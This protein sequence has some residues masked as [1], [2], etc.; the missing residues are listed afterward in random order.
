MTICHEGRTFGAVPHH[1]EINVAKDGRHLFATHERSL[2]NKW[3]YEKVMKIMK[4]KFPASEG[5]NVTATGE[6][7]FGITID[8]REEG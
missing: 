2:T 7:Q 4:E 6:Y 1:Y 5:Y 8:D 3:D